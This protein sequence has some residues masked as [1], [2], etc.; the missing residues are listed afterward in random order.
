MRGRRRPLEALRG[1]SLTYHPV[2]GTRGELPDGFHHLRRS[3]VVGQGRR[4]FEAAAEA[5]LHWQAQ[6]RSGIRVETSTVAAQ[7]GTVLRLHL[8]VGRLAVTAPARVLYVVDEPQRRGFAYGTLP[9]HPESGEESFVVELRGD[10][11]VVFTVTAYS[12]P[13]SLLTRAAGPVNRA[14]QRYMA[15]RYLRSIERLVQQAR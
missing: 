12:K 4:D 1:Q 5:V 2:G 6:R 8:G 15:G 13:G 7:E 11:S 10:G 14:F 9:G 3:R